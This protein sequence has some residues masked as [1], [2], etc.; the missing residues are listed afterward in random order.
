MHDIAR[1]TGWQSAMQIACGCESA[2]IKASTMGG[3]EYSRP[4]IINDFPSSIWKNPRRIDKKIDELESS[5][6]RRL[7]LAK[8]ERTHYAIGILAIETE[9]ARL[10]L[11]DD[12]N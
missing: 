9:L 5:D 7:V 3:P 1:L 10:E 12:L 11:R 8:A 4:T 6:E 2:W